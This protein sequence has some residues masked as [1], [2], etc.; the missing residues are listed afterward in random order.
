MEN[1]IVLIFKDFIFYIFSVFTS[2][3]KERA[4]FG[5]KQPNNNLIILKKMLFFAKKRI[6]FAIFLNIQATL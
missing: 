1:I 6:L 5:K 4:F 2:G 3:G